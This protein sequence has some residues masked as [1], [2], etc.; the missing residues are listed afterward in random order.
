MKSTRKSGDQ[1]ACTRR[2]LHQK[3]GTSWAAPE[4]QHQKIKAPEDQDQ[5]PI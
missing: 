5:R 2:S 4:D 1:L 3:I